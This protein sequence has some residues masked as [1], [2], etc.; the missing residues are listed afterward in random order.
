MVKESIRP[1][2]HENWGFEWDFAKE[3]EES[4]QVRLNA[5]SR[6]A[7]SMTKSNK[8]P[9]E[10]DAVGTYLGGITDSRMAVY[11]TG[12]SLESDAVSSGFVYAEA[13]INGGH[14]G[15]IGDARLDGNVREVLYAMLGIL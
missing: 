15:F 12:E 10:F 8:L 6:L 14:V 1:F 2:F 11:L 4:A 9:D 13:K 5:K 7:R 3:E